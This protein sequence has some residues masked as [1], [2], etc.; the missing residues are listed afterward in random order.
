MYVYFMNFVYFEGMFV[1]VCY[2]YT[3]IRYSE[4]VDGSRVGFDV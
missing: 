2:L 4:L 1:S 3:F